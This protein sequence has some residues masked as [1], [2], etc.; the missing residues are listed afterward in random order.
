MSPSLA[1]EDILAR[2]AGLEAALFLWYGLYDNAGFRD[3][4]MYGGA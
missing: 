1:L 4:C 3:K 2:Q